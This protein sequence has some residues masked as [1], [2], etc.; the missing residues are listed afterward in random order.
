MHMFIYIISLGDFPS[1][2]LT[3]KPRNIQKI[4]ATIITLILKNDC[5]KYPSNVNNRTLNKL[6]FIF[7]INLYIITP[8]NNKY[9]I[10]FNIP[11]LTAYSK[12]SLCDLSI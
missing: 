11:L 1:I 3:Q 5:T 2:S 6:L 8:I 12:N 9:D 4:G 7:L 10:K